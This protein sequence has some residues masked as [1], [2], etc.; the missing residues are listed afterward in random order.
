[1]PDSGADWCLKPDVMPDSGADWCLK[2]DVM[3]DSPLQVRLQDDGIV[4]VPGIDERSSL[5]AFGFE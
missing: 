1:M 4:E 2:P 5:L 3:P